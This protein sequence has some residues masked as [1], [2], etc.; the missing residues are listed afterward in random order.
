MLNLLIVMQTS[1]SAALMAARHVVIFYHQCGPQRYHKPFG[2]KKQFVFIKN[3]ADPNELH[4]FCV[5]CTSFPRAP[6]F[7]LLNRSRNTSIAR[8]ARK[9]DIQTHGQEEARTTQH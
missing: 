1:Y 3:D 6:Y 8:H 2:F 7:C 4:R 9:P 5:V